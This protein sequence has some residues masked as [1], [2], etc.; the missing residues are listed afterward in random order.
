MVTDIR[1]SAVRPGWQFTV[2][3][4][5]DPDPEGGYYHGTEDRIVGGW[6]P[7]RKLA[8]ERAQEVLD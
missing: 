8:R 6:A 1:V 7:T 2:V 5:A 4:G 3:I